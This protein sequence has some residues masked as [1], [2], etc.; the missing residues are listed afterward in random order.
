MAISI[1][2][3]VAISVPI[4]IAFKLIVNFVF[5][6][7]SKDLYE[8]GVSELTFKE[9]NFLLWQIVFDVDHVA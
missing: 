5:W 6:I 3:R 7:I 9:L 1:A 8:L 4:D 2:R